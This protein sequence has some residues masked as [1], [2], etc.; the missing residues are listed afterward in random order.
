MLIDPKPSLQLN[1]S[2]RKKWCPN[3]VYL[4]RMKTPTAVRCAAEIR[5]WLVHSLS[6]SSLLSCSLMVL[7][8]FVVPRHHWCERSLPRS[9]LI[10]YAT[11][12]EFLSSCLWFF[13]NQ[14]RNCWRN[15]SG[16]ALFGA[17]FTCGIFPKNLS[18]RINV[19][20][21]LN[22]TNPTYMWFKYGHIFPNV[23]KVLS[24]IFWFPSIRIFCSLFP[25][26][27]ALK[28]AS[29]RFGDPSTENALMLVHFSAKFWTE[30]VQNCFIQNYIVIFILAKKKLS[31]NHSAL[32]CQGVHVIQEQWLQTDTALRY[33]FESRRS[34]L[35]ASGQIQVC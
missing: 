2:L 7:P 31:G 3:E 15:N 18:F 33:V 20:Y 26:A 9:V 30:I 12:P 19:T 23:L 29:D 27:S 4:H 24:V 34:H 16:L 5:R 32:V 17:A 6:N 14:P 35:Q 11:A 10:W 8:P 28:D 21:Q 22:F 1:I 25:C 13:D